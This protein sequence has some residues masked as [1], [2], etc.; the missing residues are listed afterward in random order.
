MLG[1]EGIVRA[2]SLLGR[3]TVEAFG[4]IE[5]FSQ[6]EVEVLASG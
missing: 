5:F 2:V 3:L 4:R 6:D 1:A